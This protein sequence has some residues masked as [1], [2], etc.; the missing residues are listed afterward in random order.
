MAGFE[1]LLIYYIHIENIVNSKQTNEQNMKTKNK[2]E[3]KK[4]I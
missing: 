1:Y 2:L 4:V 3:I